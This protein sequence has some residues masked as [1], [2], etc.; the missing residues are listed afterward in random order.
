MSWLTTP[1][2]R[3]R[4]GQLAWGLGW[5]IALAACRAPVADLEPLRIGVNAGNVPWEFEDENGELV[6]FEIDLAQAISEELGREV[7]FIELPFL[8][9]FP[10]VFSNRIDAALSSITITPDRLATLDFAQP[11]YDSDQ[12]LTVRA[13]SNLTSLADLRGKI[14][15]V[16]NTST[17]D[18][19]AQ[20]HQQT[21]GFAAIMRYEG[22][23]PAMRDLA[24]GVFDGYISDLPALLYFTQDREDLVV[25]ERIPTGEQYSIMFAKGNPL[26]DEVDAAITTLKQNGRLAAI[27]TQWFG[28]E[29]GPTTA[30][31]NVLPVPSSPEPRP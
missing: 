28:S 2:S 16:D 9:L 21:Y 18:Q 17:G 8:E 19:W 3:R 31:V 27:Y 25:V 15:A 26:R 12:S 10:A 4:L 1:Y 29:P 22:L 11:Y 13:A 24:A 20:E 5:A 6:G 23:E 30:T 14:V 7:E